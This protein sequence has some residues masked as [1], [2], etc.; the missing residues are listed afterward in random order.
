[1]EQKEHTFPLKCFNMAI[2][3]AKCS[4]SLLN[5]HTALGEQWRTALS[6]VHTNLCGNSNQVGNFIVSE[7]SPEQGIS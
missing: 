2:S 7:P 3:F 5:E 1:M 6:I 4:L